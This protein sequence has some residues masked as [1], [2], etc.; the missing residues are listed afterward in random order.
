MNTET[1]TPEPHDKWLLDHAY[2]VNSQSGEDGVIE[3]ILEVLGDP[4][5]WCVEFGAWDG[6]LLSNV[7]RLIVE[8]GYSA[9]LIEASPGRYI[10]L[11][12]TFRDCPRVVPVN[13]FVGFT[14]EDGLDSILA[15]T[16]V[17]GDFDVLSI[18]IDGNDYHVWESV[19]RYRPRLVVIEHNP[20]IP[21]QVDFVQPRDMDVHQGSS[22]LALARLGKR[23]GYELVCLTRYN[24]FFVRSEDFDLFGIADNS[25]QALRADE[26]LV[27]YIFNGFDG[28]IFV[29]GHGKVAWHDIPYRESS[30]QQIARPFR[31]FPDSSGLLWNVL[32]K[33]YRSLRKRL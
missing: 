15:R 32:A 30:L 3:R 16:D 4:N 2:D 17:P 10:D 31:R 21:S 8:R 9:V 20:T 11:V 14:P 1:S 5:R 33:H 24:C 28:T 22:A 18:D 27:T 23:K 6:R 7:N 26:S 29:R 13:E 12:E 19:E 25:V